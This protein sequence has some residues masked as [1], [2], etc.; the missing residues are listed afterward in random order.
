MT[1]EPSTVRIDRWLWAA[2]FYK[3]RSLASAAVRGGR[4]HL[5][6]V[7]VKPAR[8]VAVGDR[9]EINRDEWRKEVII[10]GVRNQRGSATMAAT[11]YDET[12][13]SVAR[14]KLTAEGR[15]SQRAAAPRQRPDKRARRKLRQL[16]RGD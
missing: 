10:T 7:R 1:E 6:G 16:S 13:D 9:L 11:M 5:N 14:R 12:E 15:R 4:V 3:T 8:A 2:R